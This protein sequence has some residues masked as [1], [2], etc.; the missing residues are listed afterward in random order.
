M[1]AIAAGRVAR[2]AALLDEKAPGW[3]DRLDGVVLDLA[4]PGFC[5]LVRAFPR[6]SFGDSVA[7]LG[8]TSRLVEHGLAPS[9]AAPDDYGLI[10]ASAVWWTDLE[11]AWAAEIA[12]RR[13]AGMM[14]RETR[15][16][17]TD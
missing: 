7:A 11:S 4:D 5:L 15:G 10:A 6:R 16:D 1:T 9:A 17:D 3:A 2:C 12:A 13:P 14:S 8:L